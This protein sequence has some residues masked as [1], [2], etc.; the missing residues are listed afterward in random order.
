M[1]PYN[2]YSI[3]Y[4]IEYIDELDICVILAIY[5]V[6]TYIICTDVYIY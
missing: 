6:L 3:I 4:D 2:P 5:D 1:D